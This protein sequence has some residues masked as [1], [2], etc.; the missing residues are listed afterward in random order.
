MR[1]IMKLRAL[2]LVMCLNMT[3]SARAEPALWDSPGWKAC[4]TTYKKIYNVSKGEPVFYAYDGHK[5]GPSMTVTGTG[6]MMAIYGPDRSVFADRKGYETTLNCRSAE[7]ARGLV[8]TNRA[9]RYNDQLLAKMRADQ[10]CS[11]FPH[12]ASEHLSVNSKGGKADTRANSTE[13]RNLPA[14]VRYGNDNRD[15]DCRRAVA[16]VRKLENDPRFERDRLIR[17]QW[18]EAFDAAAARGCTL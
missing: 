14:S 2:A 13:F 17:L 10:R 6:C 3:T 7:S 8:C 5:C 12:L 9:D 1:T 15:Q 11:G 16:N 18:Q 4:M